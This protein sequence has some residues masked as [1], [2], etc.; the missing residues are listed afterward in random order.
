MSFKLTSLGDCIHSSDA[1]ESESN[2]VKSQANQSSKECSLVFSGGVEDGYS[3][4]RKDTRAVDALETM[5]T[6]ENSH[7]G[8]RA[9]P[10]KKVAKSVEQL[11]CIYTNIHS[12]GNK[13]EELKAIVQLENYGRIAVTGTWW[14]DSHN[15]SAAMDGCKTFRREGK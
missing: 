14:E 10:P 6:P 12:T 4:G 13:Q 2:R 3:C 15:W 11:K 9:S 7:T 5:E 1:C 8:L